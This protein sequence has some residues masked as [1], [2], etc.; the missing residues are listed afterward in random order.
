MPLPP[1]PAY[2]LHSLPRLLIPPAFIYLANILCRVLL[3]V[4][5]PRRLLIAACLL[6]FP[7]AAFI[8]VRWRKYANRKEAA[9]LGAVMPPTVKHKWPGGVDILL[10]VSRNFEKTFLGD[11]LF[12]WSE[13][14][15]HTYN[16]EV[17][18]ENRL[19]TSEPEH[20][21]AI[22]AT[23]FAGFEKGPNFRN[24]M[25]SLLGTGVFNSDGE[26]WKFHRAMTRPFF[27]RDRVSHFD[28][29]DR[30]VEDA[31]K[32]MRSRFQEGYAVDWQDL[33]SRFT[34]DSATEFLFGQDV[35]SLSAG[36]PYPPTAS[37]LARVSPGTHPANGFARAFI[38]AQTACV[39]RS[40]FAST[41]PLFEF[42]EDKVKAH[43]RAIDDF[44]API[45]SNALEKRKKRGTGEAKEEVDDD[46]TLL[47]HLV[48]L[49]DDPKV[50]KDETLNILIAGRDTTAATLT[51]SVY[52]LAQHPD[53]LQ[54]LREEI[55]AKVGPSR[56]PTYDD[57][58]DMKYLRA[59][60][61][62]TLRLYPSVPFNL[63][64]TTNAAIWPSKIPGGKPFYIPASTR[65]QYS[66]FVMHR[67]KDL[68]GPD[69][70]DFDPGRFMDERV[71]KYL[72][73][74]PFIFLPFNAGPRICLGQ[75]VRLI[76]IGLRGEHQ[77]NLVFPYQ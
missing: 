77:F 55:L 35:R 10:A 15:G 71:Q 29:F 72:T 31:F 61:N 5:V 18:F 37:A 13:E 8:L 52:K 60:I 67:R 32:Q 14:Y 74:N 24:Q 54:R 1:G 28:I 59:V 23:D 36:L 41:W 65:V 20:I 62:E 45:L 2:L 12:K 34:L 11:W 27:S 33:V 69:A 25:G 64:S 19:F 21:K 51:F 7:T 6:S 30:H 66:V 76:R 43:M 50:L 56:R 70:L 9:S 44:I 42:W 22:L 57:I 39:L 73:P 49:T 38:N 58:R 16:R 46:E 26:M 3:D 63:R 48:K 68:W 4:V 40:R 17:L 53:V 75:Q 47:E